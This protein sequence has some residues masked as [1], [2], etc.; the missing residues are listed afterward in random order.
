MGPRGAKKNPK[1]G[2][3][4]HPG[5]F[6]DT[7]DETNFIEQYNRAVALYLQGKPAEFFQQDGQSNTVAEKRFHDRSPVIVETSSLGRR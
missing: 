4:Q 5:S 1:R 2:T 3:S 7:F 6:Q